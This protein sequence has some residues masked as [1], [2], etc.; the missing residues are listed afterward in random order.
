[1]AGWLNGKVVAVTGGET[2][3]GRAVALRCCAE[4]AAVTVAGVQKEHLDAVV[5]DAAKLPGKLQAIRCDVSQEDQVDGMV[6]KTVKDYGRLD[7]VVA[8]AATFNDTTGFAD[9][10]LAE[11]RRTMSINLDGVFLTIRAGLRQLQ[12][13]GGGGSLI[14]TSSSTVHRANTHHAPYVASKG[15]VEALM[16]TL[17]RELAPQKIRC[18]IIVPGLTRTPATVR[19]QDYIQQQLADIPMKEL[20]EPEEL[21]ALVAFAISDEVPHMTAT[22]LKVD[23]GRI[24]G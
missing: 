18:N 6:A 2:G 19:E 12:K 22:L 9:F 14:A 21:A 11:W 24:I 10:T 13:Q 3:I 15:G 16:R 17:A 8:N 4:G 5:R 7:A 23:A 1:M 20:V